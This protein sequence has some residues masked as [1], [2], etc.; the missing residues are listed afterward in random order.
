LRNHDISSL[1]ILLDE[2]TLLSHVGIVSNDSILDARSDLSDLWVFCPHLLVIEPWVLLNLLRLS[3]LGKVLLW[4]FLHG[5]LL[6][7]EIH[8]GQADLLAINGDVIFIVLIDLLDYGVF[9]SLREADLLA[10]NGGIS[11]KIWIVLFESGDSLS[12]GWLSRVI[13]VLDISNW[14]SSD[15]GWSVELHWTNILVWCSSCVGVVFEGDKGWSSWLLGKLDGNWAGLVS[16]EVLQGT[17]SNVVVEEGGE[18]VSVSLLG[19][20]DGN[21]AG[22]VSDEVLECT[23]GNVVVEEGGEVVSVSLLGKLDG[24]WA[25]LVSDEVLEGTSGNVVVE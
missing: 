20:L 4:S 15:N 6:L 25:G 22:L 18:V 24:N 19:K 12:K 23:S 8:W 2:F 17:S 7:A 13:L 5:F 21:W 9:L 1:G 14:G 16:D 3:L 11:H 10:I